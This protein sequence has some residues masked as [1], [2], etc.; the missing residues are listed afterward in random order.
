MRDSGISQRSRSISAVK[1]YGKTVVYTSFKRHS[2]ASV[3]GMGDA[4]D[5]V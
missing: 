2:S 1:T 4:I 5:D 3:S